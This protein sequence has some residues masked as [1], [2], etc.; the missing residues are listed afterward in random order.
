MKGNEELRNNFALV[1]GILVLI[2]F[3]VCAPILPKNV[4]ADQDNCAPVSVVTTSAPSAESF[5]QS[6]IKESPAHKSDAIVFAL[7]ANGENVVSIESVLNLIYTDVEENDLLSEAKSLFYS[8]D[9]ERSVLL[10][11]ERAFYEDGILLIGNELFLPEDFAVSLFSLVYDKNKGGYIKGSIPIL[12]ESFYDTEDLLWLSAVIS[13][14][15]R[16]ESFL[17]K[18]AVGN[19]V[20]NRVHSP[21]FPN[22]IKA[23]VFDTAGGVQFSPVKSGS[24]YNPPTEES[25][26]AAKVCIEGASLNDS[27]LFFYNPSISSSTYFTEKRTYIMTVGNHDFFS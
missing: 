18:I 6:P 20:I 3:I 5:F 13:A 25:I 14:E 11:G 10:M 8:F 4:S 17:G 2:T 23:V 24:I 26:L 21:L 7:R 27:I 1:W 19:V 9:K 16:G 15:A 12:E 22:S